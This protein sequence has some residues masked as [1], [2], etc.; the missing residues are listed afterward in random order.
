MYVCVCERERE[1]GWVTDDLPNG[2]DI[3]YNKRQEYATGR[4]MLLI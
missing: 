2:Q 1:N 3:E 4:L